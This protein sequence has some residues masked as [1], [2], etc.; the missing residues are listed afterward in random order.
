MNTAAS[1]SHEAVAIEEQLLRTIQPP[2]QNRIGTIGAIRHLPDDKTTAD[3]TAK[4]A[5]E[6]IHGRVRAFALVSS[7]S[8]PDIVGRAI[9]SLD[10]ARRALGRDAAHAVIQQ[11]HDGVL[12]GRSFAV[13]PHFQPI[14]D[15]RLVGRYQIVRLRH[16]VLRWMRD[17]TRLTSHAPNPA[18]LHA[19]FVQPLTHMADDEALPANIRRHAVETIERLHRHQWRPRHVLAHNDLWKG[20]ILL[21]DR[22]GTQGYGFVV[23]DWASSCVDGYAI[24]DLIRVAESLRLSRRRLTRELS[25]HCTLLNCDPVDAWGHLL[26]ALGHLGRNLEHFPR[27]RYLAM[28]EGCCR[29]LDW[30]LRGTASGV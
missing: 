1:P 3:A 16:R 10:A 15:L 2:L 11:W 29:R 7:A 24:Y 20:N 25:A 23:I 6:D 9:L 12:A 5:I 27:P 30:A 22:G 8:G 14:S 18:T 19:A 26:A 21:A 17:V 28:A 13:F 4:Y